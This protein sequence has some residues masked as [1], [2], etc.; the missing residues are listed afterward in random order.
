[1]PLNLAAC[2]NRAEL[3]AMLLEAGAH[4]DD[5][6]IWGITPLQTAVYHGAREAADLLATVALVPDALY[7]AAAAGDLDRLARWFGPDGRLLPD[8]LRLRPNLADV[9]WPPAP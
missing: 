1:M 6:H 5:V 2:F 4:V 7:I 3:V 9:G 8:A